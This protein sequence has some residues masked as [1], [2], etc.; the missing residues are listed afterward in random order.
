[1]VFIL[2]T[3][4]FCVGLIVGSEYL[5]LEAGLAGIQELIK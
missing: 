5:G 4:I 3:L 2:L 1:V